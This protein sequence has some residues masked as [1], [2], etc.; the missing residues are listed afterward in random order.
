MNRLRTLWTNWL[1]AAK[2]TFRRAPPRAPAPLIRLFGG[3]G[4][5]MDARGLQGM[6]ADA[7]GRRPAPP[8]AIEEP[9]RKA[10]GS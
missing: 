4:R 6:L 10:V 3:P 2:R 7:F 9:P 1:R 5:R 8:A